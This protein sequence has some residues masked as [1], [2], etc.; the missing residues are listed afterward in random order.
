[1]MPDLGVRLNNRVVHLCAIYDRT[2]SNGGVRADEGVLDD[3]RL[4]DHHRTAD[5]AVGYPG[6]PADRYSSRDLVVVAR[7]YGAWRHHERVEHDPVRGQQR[8]RRIVVAPM[9]SELADGDPAVARK[10]RIDQ[11]R[12]VELG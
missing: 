2:D 7:A 9:V 1:R 8:F 11:A 6:A 10:Q 3:R 12:P 4:A 5:R